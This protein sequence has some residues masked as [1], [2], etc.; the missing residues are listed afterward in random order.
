MKIYFNLSTVST[1]VAKQ[2][3]K[4]V[5]AFFLEKDLTFWEFGKDSVL[6]LRF[7]MKMYKGVFVI[8]NA[9]KLEKILSKNDILAV[10]NIKSL[11]RKL[12]YGKKSVVV[13][14]NKRINEIMK[15]LLN[16]R[17]YY[18]N[19]TTGAFLSTALHVG[20]VPGGEI[21]YEVHTVAPT[22]DAVRSIGGF[23]TLPDYSFKNIPKNYAT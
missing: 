12:G 7:P 2:Q 23:R 15:I 8:I 16:Y 5:K 10:I 21:K 3:E 14:S 20:V 6:E 22:S 13:H 19:R 18:H 11:R 17:N 1:V 9:K 4:S